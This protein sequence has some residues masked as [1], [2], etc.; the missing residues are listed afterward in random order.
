MPKAETK[1]T[2]PTFPSCEKCGELG[3]IGQCR[4]N[5]PCEPGCE[6]DCCKKKFTLHRVIK[7]VIV[8]LIILL[9]FACGMS[10][11]KKVGEIQSYAKS[12]L[13]QSGLAHSGGN[14]MFEKFGSMMG[15]KIFF[16]DKVNVVQ[17]VNKTGASFSGVIEEIEGNQITITDNGNNEKII[18]STAKTI[19]SNSTKL[20]PLSAL[21]A[22]QF[23]TGTF[24]L[25]SGQNEAQVIEV[26]E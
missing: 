25:K 7:L 2:A 1:K 18:Y 11:G 9:V 3:C 19:I 17:S 12:M 14:G 5:K 21:K 22:K 13:G 26:V 4:F 20:L 10:V 16:Q 8:L 24:V 23:I 6:L 15:N